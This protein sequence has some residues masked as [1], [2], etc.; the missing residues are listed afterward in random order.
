MK[1]VERAHVES[2]QYSA[3]DGLAGVR[4]GKLAVSCSTKKPGACGMLATHYAVQHGGIGQRRAANSPQPRVASQVGERPSA[5][6]VKGF[7]RPA[8]RLLS[9]A[10]RRPLCILHLF[11]S[12]TSR[13]CCGCRDL[14][15]VSPRR[16][17]CWLSWNG[18]HDRHQHS[19]P[20]DVRPR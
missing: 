20:P 9:R 8:G 1:R 13:T 14:L 5:V 16:Q 3:A 4:V 15:G 2:Q 12:A 18:S 17:F 11:C 10:F 6:P 7:Q 19:P